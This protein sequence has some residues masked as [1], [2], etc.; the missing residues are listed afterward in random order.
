M[1]LPGAHHMLTE[2]EAE[3]KLFVLFPLKEVRAL[4]ALPH[5]NLG[6]VLGSKTSGLLTLKPLTFH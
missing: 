3:I 4:M 1:T 2:T 6:K 5:Y